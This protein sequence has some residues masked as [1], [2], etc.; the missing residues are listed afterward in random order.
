GV[1]PEHAAYQAS[2]RAQYVSVTDDVALGAFVTLSRHEGIMPALES[3]HALGWVLNNA[4]DMKPGSN[5]VV[6]LSGRGD[7]DLDIV[8]DYLAKKA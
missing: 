8:N 7:K 6:C 1:G 2:G 3:A 4:Q 5:V